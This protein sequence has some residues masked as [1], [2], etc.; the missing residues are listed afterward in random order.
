MMVLFWPDHLV[1]DEKS[2]D[3]R[4]DYSLFNECT[5][6]HH[7]SVS[8]ISVNTINVNLMIATEEKSV[9]HQGPSSGDHECQYQILRQFSV[10]TK[11]VDQPSELQTNRL[12]ATK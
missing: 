2:E 6:F 11:M 9:H 10:W 7:N 4:G 12:L 1:P 8:Y 5:K 3:Y